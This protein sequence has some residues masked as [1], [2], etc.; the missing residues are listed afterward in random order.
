MA[1]ETPVI[2]GQAQR[3]LHNFPVINSWPWSANS[4]AISLLKNPCG[5]ICPTG[6]T[7]SAASFDFQEHPLIVLLAE[8][9]L[10]SQIPCPVLKFQ[11]FLHCFL[12]RCFHTASSILTIV[13]PSDGKIN[14]LQILRGDCETFRIL[15]F[16]I[17]PFGQR[18]THLLPAVI[19][20]QRQIR[21][22]SGVPSPWSGTGPSAPEAVLPGQ[23][24]PGSAGL[25]SVL[26]SPKF[27]G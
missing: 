9:T 22:R 6:L 13:L 8:H 3:K 20:S 2:S 24:A 26:S 14:H 19:L 25:A 7:N 10:F 12:V 17:A 4:R 27:P 16:T 15:N 11:V 5:M 21:S 23:I 18:R 1:T